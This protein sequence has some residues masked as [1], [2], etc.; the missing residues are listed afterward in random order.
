MNAYWIVRNTKILKSWEH[1]EK[2]QSLEEACTVV[3][4]QQVTVIKVKGVAE[5]EM[6]R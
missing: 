5:D 3:L 6:V 1:F 2:L 4:G